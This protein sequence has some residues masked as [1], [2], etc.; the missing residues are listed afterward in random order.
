MPGSKLDG[1]PAKLAEILFIFVSSF[2]SNDG[3]PRLGIDCFLP[4]PF[5]FIGHLMIERYMFRTTDS[6]T[7]YIT[8]YSCLPN[9][10][11]TKTLL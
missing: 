4:N 10:H 1:L 2:K 3:I 9:N 6:D 5:R 8:D 7:E 11:T